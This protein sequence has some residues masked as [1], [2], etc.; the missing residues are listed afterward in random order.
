M[1]AEIRH[2]DASKEFHAD[3]IGFEVDI[4]PTEGLAP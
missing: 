2:A 1:D 4:E 3:H